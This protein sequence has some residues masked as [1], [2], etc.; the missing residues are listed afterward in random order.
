LCAKAA[1][2]ISLS[3]ETWALVFGVWR[4]YFVSALLSLSTSLKEMGIVAISEHEQKRRVLWQ[5]L[6]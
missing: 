3:G 5:E 2:G 6:Q 1:E 4:H